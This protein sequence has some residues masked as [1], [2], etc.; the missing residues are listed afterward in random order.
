MFI[1]W[2]CVCGSSSVVEPTLSIH[3]A[4]DSISSAKKT[5]TKIFIFSL[6]KWE[7]MIPASKERMNAQ[8]LHERNFHKAEEGCV[9][10]T[11]KCASY[12]ISPAVKGPV[13][14]FVEH[15]ITEH[16]APSLH[17]EDRTRSLRLLRTYSM[18][19]L[20]YIP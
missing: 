2:S 3:K 6:V 8:F 13:G 9:P 4:L 19:S 1:F 16:C 20:L 7:H 15:L 17:C 14:M 5:K 10:W 12:R 11:R 18:F